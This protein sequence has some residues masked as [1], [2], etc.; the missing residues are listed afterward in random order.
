MRCVAVYDNRDDVHRGLIDLY[1]VW[2]SKPGLWVIVDPQFI[3]DYGRD[4]EVS[5]LLKIQ[6]GGVVG[7]IGDAVVSM[8]V[9]PSVAFG[10]YRP[11]NAGAKVGF[12]MIF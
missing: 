10:H 3:I 12:K 6:M 8:Y 1:F 9:E 7:S 2:A 4:T 11:Y 5:A